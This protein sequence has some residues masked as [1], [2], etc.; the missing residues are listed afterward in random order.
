M[1][2]D[3]DFFVLDNVQDRIEVP[4]LFGNDKQLYIEIGSGKGEFISQY[5]LLHPE[6]NFLGFEAREKRIRN[7][8]KKISPSTHPNVRLV[9]MLVNSNIASLLPPESVQG[10]FIQYPDPWPKKR[11]HKR[12]LIQQDFLNALATIM[13]PDAE[14]HI[15]TDD[16][17]YANWIA[18]EFLKNPY[19]ISVQDEIIQKIPSLED[20]IPSWYEAKQTHKGISPNY[21]LFKR[22]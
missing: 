1:I 20:H 11:H 6:W 3:R 12:R 17:D 8:L 16:L 19:F 15:S 5:A 18:E 7:I 14:V 4:A 2:E 9:R 21:M 10:V 22:I 13:V